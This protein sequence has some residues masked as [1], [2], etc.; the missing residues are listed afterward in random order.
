MLADSTLLMDFLRGRKEAVEKITEVEKTSQLFT[1][2]I[3]VFEM[4]VGVYA[5]KEDVQTHLTD[6]FS[7]LTKLI[8][9]PLDRRASLLAGKIAGS[10]IKKGQKIEASDSLIAAIAI[11]NGVTHIIT[12]NKKHFERISEI[13][14]I[15]Y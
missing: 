10:L 7:L 9:L 1:T 3:N 13:E 2:E 8:V 15:E 5:G 12:R 11:S 14:V 6:I 4:I